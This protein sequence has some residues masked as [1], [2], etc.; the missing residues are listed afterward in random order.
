MN[1]IILIMADQFRADCIGF[2]GNRQI[3][4]PYLDDLAASGCYFQRGYSNSPVC[5]PARA[6]LLTGQKPSNTGF[7][8]NNFKVPWNFENTLVHQ[9]QRSGYQT[10]NVGKNHFCPQR[11]KLGYEINLL[12]ETKPSEAGTPCEYHSWLRERGNGFYE[13]TALKHSRNAW[14]VLPWTGPTELHPSEWTAT[15]AIDQLNRLDPTRPFFMK[16]SFH[17]PHPPLDPPLH[18][19]DLYRDVELE[20]PGIGDWAPSFDEDT[21]CLIPFEGRIPREHLIRAKKAYYAQITHIDSQIGRLTDYLKDRKIF[22]QTTILFIA[23]HGEMM[24]D[25]NM[26]RK[27]QPYEGS[28]HIPFIIKF[29]KGCGSQYNGQT[30]SMPVSLVDIMPTCLDLA[31]VENISPCDGA[32]LL[33][34]LESPTERHHITGESYRDEKSITSGGMYVVTDRY[35]YI[36]DSQNGIELLFDLVVDPKEL[37]NLAEN[38]AYKSILVELRQVVI[39]EYASRPEDQMLEGN[40]QLRSGR[41]L[42]AYRVPAARTCN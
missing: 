15:T 29:G 42:P 21:H 39:D 20:D 38:D 6:C 37:H 24:G 17:R 18:C 9:L 40:G 32:S 36:W 23:D 1:N 10:I 2:S 27:G 34:L 5:V 13:D 26:F 35:K 8:N 25:H 7:F 4:T 30:T 22:D 16:V 14:T 28:A 41:V 3:L 31:G 33:Q 11:A 19:W 12:Y